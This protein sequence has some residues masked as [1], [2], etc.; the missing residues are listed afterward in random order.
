MDILLVV[1]NSISMARYIDRFVYYFSVLESGLQGTNWQAA[2][3]NVNS[4]PEKKTIMEDGYEG[5]FYYLENEYGEISYNNEKVSILTPEL[6]KHFSLTNLFFN[7]VKCVEDRESI[8]EYHFASVLYAVELHNSSH[9]NF[10]R[11]GADFV[12]ILFTDEG[13]H[14]TVIDYRQHRTSQ[15]GI[16]SEVRDI[17]PSKD[18][19]VHGI[20]HKSR[21]C[22]TETV[23]NEGAKWDH[24]IV[25]AIL[26]TGG[27]GRN[28]CDSDHKQHL[29]DIANAIK[30]REQP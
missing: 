8:W 15:I 23:P 17:F 13:D 18:F 4:N 1:D 7:T 6:G 9:A 30:N 28:I 10:F 16:V 14:G 25:K 21:A 29:K 22:K 5:A 2:I 24:K 19:I 3:I 12:V 26:A 27:I 11:K 20:F